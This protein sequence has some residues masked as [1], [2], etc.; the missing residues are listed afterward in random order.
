MTA[1]QSLENGTHQY[2]RDDSHYT[3]FTSV[4]RRGG[5]VAATLLALCFV[6]PAANRVAAA[7]TPESQQASTGY[8]PN[9]FKLSFLDLRKDL[10]EA[11]TGGKQG[12]MVLFSIRGCAYCKMMVERSFR[13][14]GIEAVLRRHFD[15]VHLDIRSDLDLK[16][17]RGRAMT[18][19]EFARREGTTFSPSV[20]FYGLDGHPLLRV[21]G[22]QTPE[23]FRAT[24]DEVIAKLARTSRTPSPGERASVTRAD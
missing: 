1:R 4:A 15:V 3:S 23:R 9:W 16:D 18:V 6:M 7:E 10:E 22:Y 2:S 11:G 5:L 21:V 12:V 17:P 8:F 19:R 24:L 13:D 20:A 14:P